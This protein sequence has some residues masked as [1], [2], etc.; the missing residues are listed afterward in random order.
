MKLNKKRKDLGPDIIVTI[1]LNYPGEKGINFLIELASITHSQLVNH[2]A[3]LGG[4][5]TLSFFFLKPHNSKNEAHKVLLS[6]LAKL[7]KS[8]LLR[9]FSVSP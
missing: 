2:S 7:I 9:D 5:S 4:R 8:S 1:Y 3:N 6:L